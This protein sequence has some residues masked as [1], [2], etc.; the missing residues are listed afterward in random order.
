MA[1]SSADEQEESVQ[2]KKKQRSGGVHSDDWSAEQRLD[3]QQK[4][5]HN[6]TVE[7]SGCWL[8]QKACDRAGYGSATSSGKTYTAHKLS[9]LAFT[10]AVPKG[11]H[12]QH[13]CANK[14]CCSPAHLQVVDDR[15][16]DSSRKLTDE[17]I[18]EIYAERNNGLANT[19]KAKKYEVSATTIGKIIKGETWTH[20][21]GA[22]PADA[23][24]PPPRRKLTDE[25]IKEIYADRNNG[26]T[27]VAK[28][29]KYEVSGTTIEKIVKGK[30]W[31]HITGAAPAD[32]SPPPPRRKLTDEQIQEIY[33][34]RDNGV[35]HLLKA[36]KY[37]VSAT[38]IEEITNGRRWANITG[39]PP[40]LPP[41]PR[42]KLT[43][44]QIKE[45]YADR[46]NGV[47]NSL[48]AKKYDVSTTTIEDITKGTRWADITGA[49][50]ALPP[51]GP[52][53]K[54]T[55]AQIKEIYAGRNNGFSN[56][57]KAHMNKVSTTTIEDIT[58]GK[59]WAHITG[60]SAKR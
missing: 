41:P 21:T 50:P 28:A 5:E 57:L 22:V 26:V 44:A 23:S 25:Q 6:V 38:T 18:E 17:Q 42:R 53:R 14:S 60:A 58:T 16:Q 56:S 47:A 46:N 51:T 40:A 31:T 7:R 29:K 1:S 15:L 19:T 13:K 52:R 37:D 43:E 24:P 2:K 36:K 39:A 3:A 55:D 4:I 10:G 45:I 20:L 9:Y 30:T 35:A 34:E 11:Q 48:K 33:A 32:A 49:P 27:N 8:W 59:R 54:L 12:I